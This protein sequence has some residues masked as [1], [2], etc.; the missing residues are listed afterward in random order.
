MKHILRPL[1]LRTACV[2]SS[3]ITAGLLPWSDG[4]AQT[5]A[6]TPGASVTKAAV[7]TDNTV[8]LARVATVTAV[9]ESK[10]DAARSLVLRGPRGRTLAVTADEGISNFDAIKEGDKVSAKVSEAATVSVRKGGDGI[11]ESAVREG[12]AS[13]AGD[14]GAGA[15]AARMTTVV[16]NVWAIDRKKQ[17]LSLRGPKGNVTDVVVNDPA[18]LKGLAIGDQLEVKYVEA[19][20]LGITRLPK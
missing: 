14:A 1:M 3:L 7:G 16:A 12:V 17:V 11:R 19:V 4:H 2:L 6:A 8:A 5:V 18:S 10:D 15:A 9:V 13:S 20:A